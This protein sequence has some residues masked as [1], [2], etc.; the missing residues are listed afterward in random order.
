MADRR[1]ANGYG[2]CY[3]P[4]TILSG[5][6][7]VQVGLCA[8]TLKTKG[9]MKSIKIVSSVELHVELCDSRTIVDN[10]VSSHGDYNLIQRQE[11]HLRGGDIWCELRGKNPGL[12]Y[13]SRY[14]PGSNNYFSNMVSDNIDH[15]FVRRI[16]AP[17]ETS[18]HR[19][20]MFLSDEILGKDSTRSFER[21]CHEEGG[22]DC[23]VNVYKCINCVENWYVFSRERKA[24]NNDEIEYRTATIMHDEVNSG[25]SVFSKSL[26]D[27]K[28]TE[29]DEG[30]EKLDFVVVGTL[31]SVDNAAGFCDGFLKH[32]NK[33]NVVSGFRGHS[34][35]GYDIQLLFGLH[36]TDLKDIACV[37]DL[38]KKLMK[39]FESTVTSTTVTVSTID[40]DQILVVDSLAA[41]VAITQNMMTKARQESVA[42]V[43]PFYK[44]GSQLLSQQN[45]VKKEGLLDSL[46]SYFSWG[47]S[48]N[49]PKS[50]QDT[51]ESCGETFSAYRDVESLVI[52]GKSILAFCGG[53]ALY[54]TDYQSLL[55]TNNGSEPSDR[56]YEV[57]LDDTYHRGIWSFL[58]LN[59][60]LV[61]SI[62]KVN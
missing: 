30:A 46:A 9:G 7:D 24:Q 29:S 13:G 47:V 33:L 20:Y 53:F 6:E 32:V 16:K 55:A 36:A 35:E 3:T 1:R 18:D 56:G 49:N 39:V 60:P 59:Q 22:F 41:D 50:M 2:G 15:H 17:W 51:T 25:G 45:A 21:F 5:P 44:H 40:L 58:N 48:V 26:T 54:L 42:I 62:C 12:I 4:E 10:P 34:G 52:R 37:D 27:K 43:L 14:Q 31:D 23:Y 19:L 38:T 28:S 61:I 57:N 8:N 11:A